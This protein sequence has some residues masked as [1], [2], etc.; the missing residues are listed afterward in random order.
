MHINI[1]IN[2]VSF[3]FRFHNLYSFVFC[4]EHSVPCDFV[5]LFSILLTVEDYAFDFRNSIFSFT[6][7]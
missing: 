6:E 4:I 5:S 7:H 1:R 2:E 3:E